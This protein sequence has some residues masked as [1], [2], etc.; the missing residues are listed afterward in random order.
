MSST[1]AIVATITIKNQKINIGYIYT[2]E[3][4]IEMKMNKLLLHANIWIFLTNLMMNIDARPK[5]THKV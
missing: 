1:F 4:C 2:M 3:Y 5:R